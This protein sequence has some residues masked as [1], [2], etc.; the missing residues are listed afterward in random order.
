MTAA[1][2]VSDS[3][4]LL[5]PTTARLRFSTGLTPHHAAGGPFLPLE[6]KLD[7]AF[8]FRAWDQTS[9][10]VLGRADT[11][12]NGGGSAF[13][14]ASET[15]KVYFEARLFRS[16]NKNAELNVYTLEAEFNALTAN[17]AFMDLAIDS[18]TGFSILMSPVPELGTVPLFRMYFG[19]QFNDDGTQTDMGYRYLT[20]S[21]AEAGIL[22]GLGRA[23]LRAAR[24]GAYFREIGDPAN[25][26]DKGSTTARRSSATFTRHN[27]LAHWRCGRF[28]A[29]TSSRSRPAPRDDGRFPSEFH[30]GA[31]TGGPCLHNEHPVRDRQARYLARRGPAGFRAGVDTHPCQWTAATSFRCDRRRDNVGFGSGNPCACSSDCG[32]SECSNR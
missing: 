18:F 22:E 4:A 12:A 15:V 13:S 29:T 24:Q 28:T 21:A 20:S 14:T 9:G 30:E 23:D 5:L 27:S 31:G 32:C 1:G 3:S 25:P 10:T 17:P 11:T 2:A 6:S 7:T 19:V 8:T 26:A 16:F